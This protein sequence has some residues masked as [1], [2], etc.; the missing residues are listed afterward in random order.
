MVELSTWLYVKLR[1]VCMYV[2]VHVCMC[3]VCM[4]VC[5]YVCLYVCMYVCICLSV[6]LSVCLSDLTGPVSS[7]ARTTDQSNFSVPDND[8]SD[9]S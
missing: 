3:V 4:Y 8:K 7:E 9:T 2:R 6:C 5:M 1:L